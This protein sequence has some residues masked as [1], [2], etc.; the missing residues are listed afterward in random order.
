[1]ILQ[2]IIKWSNIMY[3]FILVSN[4]DYI[5]YKINTKEIRILLNFIIDPIII[6]IYFT[7]S[8]D[9]CSPRSRITPG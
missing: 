1:M 2:Q 3:F 6:P 7:S 8:D 5:L 4:I 9:D